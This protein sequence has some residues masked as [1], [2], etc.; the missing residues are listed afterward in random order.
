MSRLTLYT[1]LLLV[2]MS[3]SVLWLVAGCFSDISFKLQEPSVSVHTFGL[4]HIV[5]RTRKQGWKYE[6]RLEWLNQNEVVYFIVK[7]RLRSGSRSGSLRL[8]LCDIDS[9]TWR[10]SFLGSKWLQTITVWLLTMS[11]WYSGWH[12]GWHSWWHSGWHLVWHIGWHSKDLE[13]RSNFVNFW[14]ETLNSKDKL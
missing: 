10:H 12:S 14:R 5:C 9:V 7:L 4:S 8:L 2:R 11:Y 1:R 3:L 13:L 6:L